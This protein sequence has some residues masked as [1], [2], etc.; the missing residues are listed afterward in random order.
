MNSAVITINRLGHRGLGIG[1]NNGKIVLVPFTAPGDRVEVEILRSHR[2]YD[3]AYPLQILKASVWRRKPPCPLFGRCGGCRCQHINNEF[4]LGIKN[5]LSKKKYLIPKLSDFSCKTFPCRSLRAPN[6]C[7]AISR[8]YEI[9]S[10]LPRNDPLK[11]LN[12]GDSFL[13][14]NR[15]YRNF[16]CPENPHFL[17]FF[18]KIRYTL[19]SCGLL[20]NKRLLPPIV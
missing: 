12:L 11:S 19:N 16:R 7:A 1:R 18:I 10:A 5:N 6:G 13:L 15:L 4:E 14:Q 20:G 9:A 2:T 17:A 3:E 8:R